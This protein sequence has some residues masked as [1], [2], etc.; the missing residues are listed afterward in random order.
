[1][2]LFTDTS[3]REEPIN[4]S[5]SL[6]TTYNDMN[7]DNLLSDTQGRFIT[8]SISGRNLP[9]KSIVTN[10]YLGM[11]GL[12][13]GD[14][15]Y[16]PREIVVKFLLEDKTNSGFR[17]RFHR[18]YTLLQGQK[19]KLRFTD[20]NAYYLATFKEADIPEEDSNS[21]EGSLIFLCTDPAK[22]FERV[23]TDI[24]RDSESYS[25]ESI[26]PTSWEIKVNFTENVSYFSFNESKGLYIYLNYEFIE[27]DQLFIEY[28]KRKVLLNSQH[29]LRKTVSLQSSFQQLIPGDTEI[30]TSH[31]CTLIYNKKDYS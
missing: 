8:T 10:E 16:E 26:E 2:Y 6:Q 15:K 21:I 5:F 24:N 22:Y 11:H 28:D 25:I 23:E 17:N 4:G 31:G 1:M 9:S 14:F 27:G 7:I 29:D 12:R 13:E 3:P 30:I 20:E 19:R 18:L